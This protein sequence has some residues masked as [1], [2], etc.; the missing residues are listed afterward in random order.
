MRYKNKKNREIKI[1]IV[2]KHGKKIIDLISRKQLNNQSLQ[3][4]F[5]H[6]KK[7]QFQYYFENNLLKVREHLSVILEYNYNLSA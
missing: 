2:L 3:N 6:Q 7:I 4:H 1:N 5:L